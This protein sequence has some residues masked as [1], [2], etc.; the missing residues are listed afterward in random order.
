[1]RQ[2]PEDLPSELERLQVSFERILKGSKEGKDVEDDVWDVYSRLE[3][4]T[5]QIKLRLGVEDPPTLIPTTR[6]GRPLSVY[7]ESCAASL[8]EA[9]SHTVTGEEDALLSSIREARNNLRRYLSEQARNAAN[10]RRAKLRLNRS[11]SQPSSS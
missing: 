7:L 1:M 9:L 6:S 10:A 2:M 11:R 4:L 5:A 8:Q 3:M